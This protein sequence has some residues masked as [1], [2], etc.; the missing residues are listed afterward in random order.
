MEYK[1]SLLIRFKDNKVYAFPLNLKKSISKRINELLNHYN[2]HE[3]IIKQII[4]ELTLASDDWVL[5]ITP[6]DLNEIKDKLKIKEF[7]IPITNYLFLIL[8]IVETLRND[9]ESSLRSI[10][11]AGNWTEFI[12][13]D[14]AHSIL[15]KKEY[16]HRYDENTT[17]K[18]KD[19]TLI[20]LL[21]SLL[22]K[23][24]FDM[25]KQPPIFI[26]TVDAIIKEIPCLKNLEETTILNK[27]RYWI[28]KN[29][30]YKG[31]LD[32]KRAKTG[33]NNINPFLY[34]FLDENKRE[35]LE[36]GEIIP[37]VT[38]LRKVNE[39][40][41]S[42][43][44][45]PLVSKWIKINSRCKFSNLTDLIKYFNPTP[46]QLGYTMNEQM[47]N[48]RKSAQNFLFLLRK[49]IKIPSNFLSVVLNMY[50]DLINSISPK[51]KHNSFDLFYLS[52]HFY[53]SR[54][55]ILK[56]K[57]V[58]KG[59]LN[60]IINTVEKHLAGTLIYYSL[61]YYLY[62]KEEVLSSE[63][64]ELLDKITLTK[65]GNRFNIDLRMR[66]PL[67][68]FYL[69]QI[70]K[71]NVI[72][73]KKLIQS[74]RFRKD[75]NHSNFDYCVKRTNFINNNTLKSFFDT[76]FLI[77]KDGKYPSYLFGFDFPRASDF[78]FIGNYDNNLYI[79][80]IKNF[81]VVKKNLIEY[82]REDSDLYI[83]CK[84]MQST[85]NKYGTSKLGAKRH[86]LISNDFLNNTFNLTSGIIPLCRELPVWKEVF[87]NIITGHIDILAYNTK[88]NEFLILDIKPEGTEEIFKSIPQ[89]T[90]YG[91]LL[92]WLIIKF[93]K[94]RC[95]DISFLNIIKIK[96][97][98]FNNEIAWKFDPFLVF[99]N[100][101]EF[102]D[103]EY[104]VANRKKP[105]RFNRNTFM[106]LSERYDKLIK[107]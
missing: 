56:E 45:L 86:E 18:K 76:L 73:K 32:M 5:E 3:V 99:N 44:T 27:V 55:S 30:D 12:V 33:K 98:G 63:T 72:F 101:F 43:S 107:S 70:P 42:N 66:S 25:E 88:F 49:K 53:R 91:F 51:G 7:R 77:I 29:T 17:H 89:L 78:K 95:L 87:F 20:D 105:I 8:D 4:F 38:N 74:W 80:E 71:Y 104:N 10:A 58:I 2:D 16:Y 60:R 90:A 61:L 22:S 23:K 31:V 37:N 19:T 65:L 68:Y 69:K 48:I 9:N 67:I 13:S 14:I 36:L 40:F 1:D 35:I 93:C 11:K 26:P 41:N 52:F 82:V 47:N 39:L 106:R 94:N 81:F 15:D 6:K 100:I 102:L 59:D 46:S 83:I 84:T 50:K 24:S 75:R 21:E 96:C 103:Y 57:K 34:E 79:N 28:N 54:R 92:K 85:Y 97:V 64:L 62:S